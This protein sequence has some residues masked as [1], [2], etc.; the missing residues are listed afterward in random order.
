MKPKRQR[1]TRLG[2][3]AAFLFLLGLPGVP[4]DVQALLRSLDGILS[5]MTHDLARWLFAIAALGIVALIFYPPQIRK[6]IATTLRLS[7]PIWQGVFAPSFEDGGW[8]VDGAPRVHTVTSGSRIQTHVESRAVVTISRDIEPNPATCY[9]RF[10]GDFEPLSHGPFAALSVHDTRGIAFEVQIR[11]RRIIDGVDVTA[12][13]DIELSD[14]DYTR[15]YDDQ[16][17][18]G[19]TPFRDTENRTIV[20]FDRRRITF[21]GYPEGQYAY[22]GVCG[23]SIKVARATIDA[24]SIHGQSSWKEKGHALLEAK[25]WIP[26]QNAP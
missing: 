17:A 25:T 15:R 10:K 19:V 26:W 2:L 5:V 14:A 9:V 21:D 4:G 24:V 22:L 6:Q 13:V 20:V 7:R 11:L 23:I 3:W 16:W 12:T 1:I 8:R 18:I